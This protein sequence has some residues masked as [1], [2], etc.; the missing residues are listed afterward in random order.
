MF[1]KLTKIFRQGEKSKKS[2][3]SQLL[4]RHIVLKDIGKKLYTDRNG[5]GITVNSGKHLHVMMYGN[6]DLLLYL[7]RQITLLCH[8]PNFDDETGKNRSL[9]TFVIPNKD[10][11][12]DTV[13]RFKDITG[14]LLT[15]EDAIGAYWDS[16]IVTT[17]SSQ[18]VERSDVEQSFLDFEF[19]FVAL[20]DISFFDYVK[21]KYSSI[22]ESVISTFIC[23]K[24]ALSEEFN[25]A[26]FDNSYVIDEMDFNGKD[27]ALKQ[28][29]INRA[30]LVNTVYNMG[31]KLMYIRDMYEVKQYKIIIDILCRYTSKSKIN[32]FWNKASDM[33]K[34]S[35]LCCADCFDVKLN[36]LSKYGIKDV[37]I[38]DLI[39]DNIVAL[40]VSEHARWNMEKFILG[41]SPYTT[42]QIYNDINLSSQERNAERKRLKKKESTHIN[43]CSYQ[44][45]MRI[46]REN[47]KYDCFLIL[48]MDK[49]IKKANK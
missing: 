49:I 2:E 26:Y 11:L 25:T 9:I 19:S 40:A 1:N 16:R 28:E 23:C 46:D 37:S 12:K 18:I 42:E 20:D 47:F 32:D 44:Q 24:G 35:S 17:D 15:K 6:N 30:K 22:D 13:E 36:S 8:F 14:N 43:L 38:S 5:E 3:D 39:K 45:L 41:F 27:I 29:D 34:F 48:A 7:A 21:G 33:D 10:D 4:A 31:A